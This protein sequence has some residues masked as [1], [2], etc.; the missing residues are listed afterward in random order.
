MK[1]LALAGIFLFSTAASASYLESCKFIA[2][3]TEVTNVATLN[4]TVQ[5]KTGLVKIDIT[6]VTDDGSHSSTACAEK[7]GKEV[8][9]L[10]KKGERY[11]LRDLLTINYFYVSSLTPDGSVYSVTWDVIKREPLLIDLKPVIEPIF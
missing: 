9:L 1:K 11:E 6:D 2:V 4:D 3:V 5:E 7:K 10:I 8:T